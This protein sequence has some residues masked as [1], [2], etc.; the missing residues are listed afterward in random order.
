VP[1]LI[2]TGYQTASPIT[3]LLIELVLLTLALLV[4]VAAFVG[5]FL[6][7]IYGLAVVL[8]AVIRF[9]LP[10]RGRHRR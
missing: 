3:G 10:H 6:F 4:A 8:A 9:V 1:R 7:L 2:G 5:V